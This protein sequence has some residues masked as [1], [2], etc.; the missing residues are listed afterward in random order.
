MSETIGD[1]VKVIS[2]LLGNRPDQAAKISGWILNG[3]RDIAHSIPFEELEATANVLCIPTI[4]EYDYPSDARGINFI[5]LGVPASNPT[6]NPPLWKRNIAIIRRYSKSTTGVPS[7]WAPYNSQI[8][9]RQVP[10]DGYPMTIDYWRKV[11]V[12]SED[13]NGTVIE[14]PDDWIEIVDYA[15][16][17]RGYIDLQQ[18]DRAGAIRTLLYGNPK[19]PDKPGLIKQ[20]LTRIQSEYAGAS[21]GVRPRLVRYTC[22]R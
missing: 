22:V 12:D 13:I 6:S 9:L 18:P 5:T 19:F 14:V 20:R 16:Q 21:Y 10:N 3:Y 7:I 2:D 15:A 17:I 1:R 11:Q 4:A 8:H